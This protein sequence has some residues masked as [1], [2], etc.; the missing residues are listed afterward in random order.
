MIGIQPQTYTGSV[1][2]GDSLKCSY[3]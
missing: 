3:F 2:L 1:N